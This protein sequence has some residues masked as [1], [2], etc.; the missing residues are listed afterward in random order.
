VALGQFLIGQL[1]KWLWVH[2]LTLTRPSQLHR[3]K[4]QHC[5][6]FVHPGGPCVDILNDDSNRLLRSNPSGRALAGAHI[7]KTGNYSRAHAHQ[8]AVLCL[9]F[10]DGTGEISYGNIATVGHH[11]IC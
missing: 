2:R 10:S 9:V 6:T 1:V 5:K 11:K 7:V 3:L 8:E 4:G